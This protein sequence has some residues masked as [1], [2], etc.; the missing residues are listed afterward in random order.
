[1]QRKSQTN[2]KF[3]T[4]LLSFSLIFILLFFFSGTL[5]F[6]TWGDEKTSIIEVNSPLQNSVFNSKNILLNITK[7]NENLS[8]LT[9]FI[10]QNKALINSTLLELNQT[11][12][13]NLTVLNDGIYSVNL[14]ACDFAGNCS[15]H[16]I[17]N[18]SVM[19]N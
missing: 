1:M 19:S 7:K 8:N 15:F 12:L 17:E 13:L 14:T 9:L 16:V 3:S 2:L 5:N 6:P 11:T 18:I 4:F 10:F